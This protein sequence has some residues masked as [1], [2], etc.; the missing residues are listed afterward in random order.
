MLAGAKVLRFATTP[1]RG[2]G[3]LDTVCARASKQLSRPPPEPL[4]GR[5]TTSIPDA[6]RYRIPQE[7]AHGFLL[8]RV[9]LALPAYS[10]ATRVA[11]N[12]LPPAVDHEHLNGIRDT[13]TAKSFRHLIESG[14]GLRGRQVR[15]H[16]DG[17]GDAIR[18]VGVRLHDGVSEFETHLPD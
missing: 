16:Y 13:E 1:L 15:R 12:G 10:P 8:M 17:R 9:G 7:T 2:A 4:P 18:P 6:K 14:E 11:N 3:D 5:A